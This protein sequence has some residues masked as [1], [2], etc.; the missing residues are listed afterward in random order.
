[1]SPTCAS[2][3]KALAFIL[4][5]NRFFPL[6]GLASPYLPVFPAAFGKGNIFRS[7]IF[8]PPPGSRDTAVEGSRACVR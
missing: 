7:V 4:P 2:I 5:G 6:A 3:G 8:G 1:M